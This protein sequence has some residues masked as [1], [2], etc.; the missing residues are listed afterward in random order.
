MTLRLCEEKMSDLRFRGF[1]GIGEAEDGLVLV[2]EMSEERLL[3]K[4]EA[5]EELMGLCF[6]LV[7][8]GSRLP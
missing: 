1:G 3:E 6:D 5:V 7:F 4:A 2:D 8:L